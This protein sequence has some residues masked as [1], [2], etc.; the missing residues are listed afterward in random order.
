MSVLSSLFKKKEGSTITQEPMYGPEQQAALQA[1]QQFY[2]TGKLGNYTAGE[3]YSGDLGDFNMTDLEKTGQSKLK[4]LVAG[5]LPELFNLGSA[6][7]KKL[8]TT[9]TYDPY[10]KG[11][12]Y[13]GF[14][15]AADR[16]TQ[17]GSTA[18]SRNLA[19]TGDLY[20]TANAKEQ[21]LLQ[22]RGVQSKQ[23]KLAEL[24]QNFSNQK[25]QGAG[26]AI[27]TGIKE[28][29]LNQGRIELTQTVGSL[30]RLLSDAQAKAQYADY[31]R[32][33][34]ELG[35]TVNAAQSVATTSIPYGV[36]SFT[37]PDSP[38]PFSNLLNAGL[39]IAGQATAAYFTGGMSTLGTTA[40]SSAAAGT[41]KN[42]FSFFS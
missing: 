32:G 20:S 38:S 17:E 37:T 25:L 34:T 4:D 7:L 21:G 22:E 31:L 41:D 36:K 29:A 8:L 14:Q 28:E 1:L 39:K 18:L 6:E 27:D 33:R 10:A 24:Y 40:A 16:A 23:N 19:V 35:Q 30:Q 42:I 12:V 13:S 15:Q 26:A 2:Q 5:G 9:D 11:G 3:A